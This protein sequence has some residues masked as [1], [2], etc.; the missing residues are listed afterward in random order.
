MNKELKAPDF[1]IYTSPFKVSNSI[2]IFLA[3]SIEMGTAVDWQTKVVKELNDFTKDLIFL[4]P[5]RDSWDSS[6]VQS[7]ENEKFY[8]QVTWELDALDKADYIFMYLDPNTMSPI[9]LL[10][11]GLYA[12]TGKLIVVCPDGFWRKGNV[13]VVCERFAI[14]LLNNLDD[15]LSHF[16]SKFN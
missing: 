14:P 5:R 11:L 6:W 12:N 9:S 4:N 7:I 3:G 16:I 8:E 13:E 10:E 2:K 1:S 15:L